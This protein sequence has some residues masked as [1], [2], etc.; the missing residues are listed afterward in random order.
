[1]KISKNIAEINIEERVP[2]NIP[3]LMSNAKPLMALPPNIATAS[4]AISV[5]RDVMMVRGRTSFIDWS[6]V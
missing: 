5:V 4:M 3:K 1:M 6:M 2:A